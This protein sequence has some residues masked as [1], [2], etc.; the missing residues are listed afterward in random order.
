VAGEVL[1][2]RSCLLAANDTPRAVSVIL[3]VPTVRGLPV[4]NDQFRP[5]SMMLH[6]RM[7]MQFS[8]RQ[9]TD[10]SGCNCRKTC[11]AHRPR[12]VTT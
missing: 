10:V 7:N 5:V 9:L 1:P 4:A 11:H 12:Q 8:I 6:V 2:E 3:N